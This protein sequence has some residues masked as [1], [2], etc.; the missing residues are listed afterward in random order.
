MKYVWIAYTVA[1]DETTAYVQVVGDSREELAHI[2]G[3]YIEG[4]VPAEMYPVGKVFQ[5]NVD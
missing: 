2:L 4:P 1:Q 5:L 3:M